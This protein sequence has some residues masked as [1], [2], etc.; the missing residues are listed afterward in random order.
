MIPGVPMEKWMSV[1]LSPETDATIYIQGPIPKADEI[2]MLIQYLELLRN[3]FA[4][5][6]DAQKSRAGGGE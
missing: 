1:P 4:E 5:K 2:S 6:D 3:A